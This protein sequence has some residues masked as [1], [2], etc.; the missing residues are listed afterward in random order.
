VYN[1]SVDISSGKKIAG[2]FIDVLER[3]ARLSDGIKK[4]FNGSFK[5]V[6]FRRGTI[7]LKEGKKCDT[8][9]FMVKGIARLYYIIDGRE[10]T[11]RFIE[12]NGVAISYYSFFSKKPSF[13]YIDLVEDCTMLAIKRAD[14]DKIY[15]DFPELH[16]VMQVMLQQSHVESEERAMILRRL[17][18]KEKYAVMIERFPSIFQKAT[19]EQIASFL[20]ITRETLSRIRSGQLIL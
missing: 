9:Y 3:V 14:L 4:A 19:T 5:E 16:K 7:L 1:L 2:P 11:N 8:A 20:G 13:E 6:Q 18:A 17:S 15:I 12:I 10:I